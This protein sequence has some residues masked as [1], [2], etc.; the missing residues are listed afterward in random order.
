MI[1]IETAINGILFGG[2]YGLLGVGLALIVGV[3]RVVNISHG[4]FIVLSAFMGVSLAAVA[5][6]LHPLVLVVPVMLISFGL[7]YVLQAVLINRIITRPDPFA[8]ILLTFGLAVVMRNLMLEGF[9]ADPRTLAAGTL[10]HA[11][12]RILGLAIGVLPLLVL[13]LSIVLFVALQ[14][15]LTRT[16][17]GRIMRA[18]ADNRDVVRLMGVNPARVYNVVM[19]LSLALA[20]VAGLLLAIR[21]SFTPYSGVDRLLIAF[22]VVVLGGLGSFWGAMLGGIALGVVQLVGLKLDPNAGPLYAHLLFFVGVLLR[23]NG[24]FGART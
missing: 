18:T 3:M 15:V 13:A 6:W 14:L 19:G 5:P 17:F 2:L 8:A 22:E 23:P 20:S 9:G 4:E 11:S 21:S 10:A 24:L 7:G 12:V 1:W 16:R